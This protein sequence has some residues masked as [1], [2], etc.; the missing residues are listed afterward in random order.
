[1]IDLANTA[2]ALAGLDQS[3]FL[4]GVFET[5]TGI[6]RQVLEGYQLLFIHADQFFFVDGQ[7]FAR[8]MVENIDSAHGFSFSGRA[9]I[10]RKLR[11]IYS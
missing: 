4:Q 11:S 2:N 3:L 1:M 9:A 10:Q 6:G 8:A 7:L 5:G